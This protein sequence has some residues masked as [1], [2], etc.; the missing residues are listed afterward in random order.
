MRPLE[1][2]LLITQSLLILSM[3][4]A[5]SIKKYI[6]KFGINK[7]NDYCLLNKFAEKNKIVF[8]GDSLTDFYPV[9]EFFPT[10][11]IYNRGVVGNT[12]K[13]LEKRLDNILELEPAKLFMQ[14]GINDIKGRIPTPNQL[15][16]RILKIAA[17]FSDSNTKIYLISLYPVNK[18]RPFRLLWRRIKNDYIQ[19]VN[20]SLEKAC[21]RLGYIYVNVHDYLLDK[22][23]SLKKEYTVDGLHLNIEGY[24]LVSIVLKPYVE[25]P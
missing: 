25:N 20:L 6:R 18:T 11:H 14:I 22:N 4:L 3:V 7:A 9:Q 8:I 10:V 17:A 1:I 23:N 24:A 13:D 21:E 12:T 15:A 19:A 2:M 5:V 16:Q